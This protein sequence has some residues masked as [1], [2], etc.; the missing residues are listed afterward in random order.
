MKDLKE[1][2]S[3]VSAVRYIT[4][5]ILFLFIVTNAAYCF[6]GGAII[7]GVVDLGCLIPLVKFADKW[8]KIE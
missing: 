3:R 4:V 7:I 2:W 1:L 5:L 8:L 6:L